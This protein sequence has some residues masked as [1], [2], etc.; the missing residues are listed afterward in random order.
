MGRQ[1]GPKLRREDQ[2]KAQFNVTPHQTGPCL[3]LVVDLGL[4]VLGRAT[5]REFG[6]KLRVR[7]SV[8]CLEQED[9]AAD[10]Q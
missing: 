3:I 7:A 9:A 5:V 4:Y 2:E 6:A 8:S 10:Q 1:P